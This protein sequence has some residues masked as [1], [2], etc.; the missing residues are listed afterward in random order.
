[1]LLFNSYPK[2]SILLLT[3]EDKGTPVLFYTSTL[4]KGRRTYREKPRIEDCSTHGPLFGKAKVDPV[5]GEGDTILEV[6]SVS[7]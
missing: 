2:V 1:M 7:V 6:V 4:L 3:T 5:R